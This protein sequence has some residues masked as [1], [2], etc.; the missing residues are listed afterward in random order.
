MAVH[1][2]FRA[3]KHFTVV[4]QW[5]PGRN[6]TPGVVMIAFTIAVLLLGGRSFEAYGLGLKR[7]SYHLSLGLV[8]SVLLIA[9]AALGLTLTRFHFDASRPP[10][11]YASPLPRIIGLA[12]VCVPAFFTVLAIFASRGRMIEKIPAAI[13]L[14][15]ILILLAVPAV[16][17]A[18]FQKPA[19]VL[20]VLWLFFGAGFGEEIFFRGYIQSRVDEA[21]GRPLMVMG[22]EFGLGLLVSSLLFGFVHALDSVDYFA[23]HFDFGWGYGAQTFFEGLFFGCLRA[24]TGSILPGAILHGFGDAFARIANLLL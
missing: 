7:W 14:P 8:C 24:K 22:F 10:D 4:G 19:A 5:N 2:T 16:V 13:T 6:F 15:A 18:R 20:T 21:F 9:I 23:G 12:V 11:P 3:I 17:L 1:L